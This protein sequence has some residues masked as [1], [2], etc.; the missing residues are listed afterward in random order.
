MLHDNRHFGMMSKSYKFDFW[1]QL[2]TIFGKKWIIQQL[3]SIWVWFSLIYDLGSGCQSEERLPAT[4]W[5]KQQ[6]EGSRWPHQTQPPPWSIRYVILSCDHLKRN[7]RTVLFSI[8]SFMKLF[9]SCVWFFF[10][11]LQH[12][13][14]TCFL[15]THT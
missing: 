3:H 7:L 13:I 9:W 10:A 8:S 6:L 15:R 14:L 12:F 5:S 2:I 1:V 4:L 11:N